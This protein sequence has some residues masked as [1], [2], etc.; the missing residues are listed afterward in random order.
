MSIFRQKAEDEDFEDEEFE[1]VEDKALKRKKIKSENR[2]KRKELSKPWGKKE[3]YLVFGAFLAT[4]LISGL[5]AASA[6]SWKLPNFP[7]ISLPSFKEETIIITS[8]KNEAQK[9]QKAIDS[10]KK[11]TDSLSGIYAFYLV[12]L[13]SGFS[14]G[15]S[16]NEVMQAASLV[17]L[18]VMATLYKEA[19]AGRI[20]LE[21]KYTLKDS[22]RVA[23]AGSLYSKPA[24]TTLTYRELARLMGK[25]SDNTALGIVR[26]TLG[27]D[28]IDEIISQ[29]G[30]NKTSLS[31]NETSPYDIGLFF[32]KLWKT[33]IVSDK[34]RDEILDYL[35]DT[36]YEKWI[37]AGIS[38]GIRVAHK[39]GVEANVVND[40]GIVFSE[41]PFVLV[42]MSKGVVVKEAN[43]VFPKLA[44]IFYESQGN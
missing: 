14:Y 29:I 33:E 10:F 18:P 44:R 8:N 16:E 9:A 25:Q 20:N 31:E 42:V 34:S 35:T 27:E 19:E 43:E 32:E 28:K 41:K 1:E 4:V 2:K 24:G 37:V 36:A 39:Y 21:S 6:R 22:D 17:K 23:G 3:R 38:P 15:V 5:L 11:E 7:K 12:K 26:R 13:E 30:M 40:A